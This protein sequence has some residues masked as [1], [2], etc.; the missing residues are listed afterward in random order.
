[1][2]GHEIFASRGVRTA[3]GLALVAVLLALTAIVAG[4]G[5]ARGSVTAAQ[6]QYGKITICHHTHSWRHPEHTITINE[7]AWPGH[8]RHG[9]TEG[10][11]STSGTTDTTTTTATI[12]TTTTG[13]TDNDDD[14]GHHGHAD[15]SSVGTGSSST[16]PP[17]GQGDGHGGG[18]GDEGANGNGNNGNGNNGNGNNGRG[19]NGNGS[20]HGDD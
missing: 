10:A 12:G 11:C 16:Q 17:T 6:Y 1:L 4:V 5:F 14:S 19:D 20:A 15:G 9:D 8:L 2:S 18:K 7:N 13:D 3:S